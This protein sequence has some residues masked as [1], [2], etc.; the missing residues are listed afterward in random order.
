MSLSCEDIDRGMQKLKP[1]MV[2]GNKDF[3]WPNVPRIAAL[4]QPQPEDFGM[5]TLE[6]A[7]S[8]AEANSH[9][10]DKHHWTHTA[11][12]EAGRRTGWFDIMGAVSEQRRKRLR[13]TF[14]RHYCYLVKR[15]MNGKEIKTAPH[16]IESDSNKAAKST[17]EK[18]LSFNDHQHQEKMRH[19]GINPQG[20]R[21]EFLKMKE[22]LLG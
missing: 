3:Q 5:P 21:A 7:W 18:S 2:S 1:L 19:Q 13:E 16:L 12:R 9:A 15:V 11:V 8:E 20:G 17:A 10:V 22:R 14:E 4:C 6:Q